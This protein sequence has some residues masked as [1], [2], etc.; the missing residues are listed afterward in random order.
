MDNMLTIWL[1]HHIHQMYKRRGFFLYFTSTRF[2][3]VQ[4]IFQWKTFVRSIQISIAHLDVNKI[5]KIKR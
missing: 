5:Q 4:F 1:F 2:L 3:V